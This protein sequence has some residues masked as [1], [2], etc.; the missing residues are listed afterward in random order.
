MSCFLNFIKLSVLCC[1][2]LGVLTSIL[3]PYR[4]FCQYPLFWNLSYF[5]YHCIGIYNQFYLMFFC[6]EKFFP[7][8]V[9]LCVLVWQAI[10]ALVPVECQSILTCSTVI[11]VQCRVLSVPARDSMGCCSGAEILS[12]LFHP[13]LLSPA[14]WGVGWWNSPV[15][16]AKWNSKVRSAGKTFERD[17]VSPGLVFVSNQRKVC[18]LGLL[19][20]QLR[21]QWLTFYFML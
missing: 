15:C 6:S 3:L 12:S 7:E 1:V 21:V 8:D 5:L 2:S 4:I 17:S 16:L 10:Q 11:A 19:G 18:N 14:G 20:A 13:V 9:Y